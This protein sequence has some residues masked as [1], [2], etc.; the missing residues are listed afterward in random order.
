MVYFSIEN[1]YTFRLTNTT[2][3]RECIASEFYNIATAY[4]F[5]ADIEELIAPREW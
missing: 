3:A 1:W 5:E 2:A 4:G